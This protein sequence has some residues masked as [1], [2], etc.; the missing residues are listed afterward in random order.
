MV[1]DGE[2]A[3]D[4]VMRCRAA[5]TAMAVLLGSAACGGSPAGPSDVR[6]VGVNWSGPSTMRVGETVK[7]SVTAQLEGGG[8]APLSNPQWASLN[9]AIVSITQDGTVTAHAEGRTEIV[10][11]SGAR[12]W[13][14]QI[15][16]LPRTPR[17]FSLEGRVHLV[18]PSAHV[19]IAGAEVEI[20]RQ[21]ALMPAQQTTSDA[22]GRFVA[23]LEEG[24]YLISVRTEAYSFL[25]KLVDVGGDLI[26]DF[27]I[28][29]G[30]G[31]A[32]EFMRLERGMPP[33]VQASATYP[34]HSAGMFV[35]WLRS[36]CFD[37][38]CGPSAAES[39]CVEVRDSNNR[40]N[41]HARLVAGHPAPTSV[42]ATEG[43][44]NTVK[45]YACRSDSFDVAP[46]MIFR[47]FV[48]EMRRPK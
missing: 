10:L 15:T 33:I 21:D 46:A 28:G 45:L 3:Y 36:A 22:S 12:T 31:A 13:G 20:T 8:S 5:L 41:G 16:V 17:V 26:V 38:S 42:A 23:S 6:I 40:L 32:E 27:P 44:F 2:R 43:L 11:T 19:A 14:G 37:K 39:A 48:L 34:I 29:M 47:E 30:P 7:I 18:P 4:P 1:G 25:N 9:P 35:L 24:R